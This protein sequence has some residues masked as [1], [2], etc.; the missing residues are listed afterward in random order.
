[1]K[2]IQILFSGLGGHGSVAFSLIEADRELRLQHIL[3]FLGT[4][5]LLEDY[6][7]KCEAHSFP[8]RYIRASARKPWVAWP[9]VARWLDA[10]R[11]DAILLHS[12]SAI[13][14]C[15]WHAWRRRIPLVAIEHTPN[16]V[17]T[18]SEWIA[19]GLTML[20]ADRVVLLT[21]QYQAELSDALGPLY[22]PDKVCIIPNGIDTDI[23]HPPQQPRAMREVWLGMAA[24]FSHAKRQEVLVQM[25]MSLR[26]L[27]PEVVWRLSLAGD[28]ERLAPVRALVSNLGLDDTVRLEGQLDESTL[29]KWYRGLDVYVHAS[30]AETLSTSLLQAMAS[31]LPVVASDIPGIR[32]LLGGEGKCGLLATN[33]GP[34]FAEQV[35]RL[36]NDVASARDLSERSRA[37]CKR[38]YS[39]VAMRDNYLTL[40]NQL[41][42]S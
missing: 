6:V 36:T 29:A 16:A 33:A 24:R 11:P 3:G 17:K 31:G 1:M 18:R 2:L 21:S 40:I 19:S 23:F 25:M 30:D 7:A 13:L 12:T 38:L 35:A 41:R 10:T 27:Y 9:A 37:T 39:N 5:P 34:A 32:N 26:R 22:R 4:A 8:Y 42:N 28:G 15:R 20:L 14:P